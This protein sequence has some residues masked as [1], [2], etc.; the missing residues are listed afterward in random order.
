M[1]ICILSNSHP[2]NDV[3]LYYKLAHS[4]AKLGEVHLITTIGVSNNTVNP[5][6][7]TVNSE[8]KW[9][10][11]SLLFRAASKYKPQLV[12]CVEPV[13]VLVGMLLR[14]RF[15]SKLIFDVH[16]FFP[17]AFAE[18]FPFPFNLPAKHLYLL[19][20]RWL[21][22]RVQLTI[23][24][25]R[26]VLK[27]LVPASRLGKALYLPNYPVKNVWDLSCEVPGG[28]GDL[29]EMS[30]DLIYVGGLNADR[31]IFKLLK[32]IS[33]IKSEFPN[34]TVLIVGKFFAK[35]A[36]QRFNSDVT[37]YNLNK[38]IYYQEWIPAEKI[39]LLLRRSRFGL[40]LFN[41]R[42]RRM[43]KAMPLKVLEYLAAGLPVI[44]IK[45]PL[46]SAL[47]EKNGLGAVSIYQSRPI[48]KA[49]GELLKLDKAAYRAMSKRCSDIAETRFNWEA[50]EPELLAAVSA[51]LKKK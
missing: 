12:I 17:D 21:E 8:S 29:C 23:G 48:A 33:R 18:R 2:S 37:N 36:Q 16:E 19:C 20:E 42:N 27:E 39:G 45:T 22:R 28:I 7:E 9:G 49:L 43:G 32:V 30:F 13:T 25:N 5:Y 26:A 38:H 46:M 40:W 35:D 11:L 15:K 41:P 10:S 44:T 34:L 4:L 51:L 1:K 50:V 47:I 6:Q 31:G 3:R 14:M 24:V